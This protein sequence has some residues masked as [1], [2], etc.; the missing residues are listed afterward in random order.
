M[1]YCSYSNVACQTKQGNDFL[2]EAERLRQ[3]AAGARSAEGTRKRS[4]RAVRL[5]ERLAIWD[6]QLLPIRFECVVEG[7]GA[8]RSMAIER[9]SEEELLR[10]SPKHK[11]R[12]ILEPEFPVVIRMSNKTTT[13]SIHILQP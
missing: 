6:T 7:D 3:P 9:Q 1:H 12:H 5:T 10:H 4:L 13:L 8:M 11:F 2:N